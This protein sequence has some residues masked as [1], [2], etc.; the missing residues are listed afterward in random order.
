MSTIRTGDPAIE[1]VTLDEAKEHCR[2]DISDDDTYITGLIKTAR[3][4]VEGFLERVLIE[5]T[6]EFQFHDF[7]SDDQEIR[8]PFPPLISVTKIE[9][10]D[11]DGVKKEFSSSK[12]I[13]DTKSIPGRV[14]LT[15][16]ESWPS[17]QDREDAVI[18]TYKAGY[19]DAATDVPNEFKAAIKLMVAHLYQERE[20]PEFNYALL[21]SHKVFCNYRS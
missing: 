9:Y 6:W 12:Y 21:R 11:D 16:G 1:P 19:G 8:L 7:P 13:V 15:Y 2:V 10:Y 17:T 18:I 3:E 5:Q 14:Y 20:N 4:C